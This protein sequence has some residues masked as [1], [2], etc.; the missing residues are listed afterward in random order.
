MVRDPIRELEFGDLNSDG[1]QELVVLE[2]GEGGESAVTF[3]YRHGW[4]FSLQWRSEPGP[5][6]D[7]V[8]LTGEST[9]SGIVSVTVVP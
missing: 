9:T 4:G 2:A 5:Y 6:G 8:L 1:T 7:V 3:W